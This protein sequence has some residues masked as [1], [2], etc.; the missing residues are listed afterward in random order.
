MDFGLT[1]RMART[2]KAVWMVHYSSERKVV[3]QQHLTAHDVAEIDAEVR[4]VLTETA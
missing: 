2:C 4:T 1:P 3:H